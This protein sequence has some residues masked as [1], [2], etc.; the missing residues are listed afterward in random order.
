MDTDAIT[1]RFPPTAFLRGLLLAPFAA[2]AVYCLVQG[3]LDA[4][5][6]SQDFQWSPTVLLTQGK[7]PYAWYLSGNADGRII[8]SQQPNYLHLLYL[9]SC[10]LRPDGLAAG[11]VRVGR[12]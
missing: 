4:L 7:N 5:V 12:S 3:F 11:Q 2:L 10:A 8:L 9:R 1:P 6:G